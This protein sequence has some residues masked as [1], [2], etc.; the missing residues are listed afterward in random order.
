VNR[1]AGT[2]SSSRR[3][4]P[5]SRSSRSRARS[6]LPERSPDGNLFRLPDGLPAEELFETLAGGDEVRVERIVSTGQASPE[7]QLFAQH[8]DEWVVLLRGEAELGY[9]DGSRLKLGPGDYVLIP[10]GVRH[11]VQWTRADPP[12]IWLAV[13]A[14]LEGR[15]D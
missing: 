2:D 4:A 12:C 1:F 7:G 15:S 13:H 6:P 14:D 11:R 3:R 9:E 10:A 8:N 5:S